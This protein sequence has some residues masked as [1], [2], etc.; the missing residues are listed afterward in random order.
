MRQM[1]I[2]N[3]FCYT[4]LHW[5]FTQDFVV[6]ICIH[7]FCCLFWVILFSHID[8]TLSSVKCYFFFY[9]IQ[10]RTAKYPINM[11]ICPFLDYTQGSHNY[12]HS[13]SFKVPHF[14][15]FYFQVF[16]FYFFNLTDIIIIII[17]MIYLLIHFISYFLSSFKF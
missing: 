6:I 9:F 1:K 4:I 7:V 10:D 2:Q 15:N 5:V 14:F 17:M 13:G 11:F 8:N 3:S 16:I 12:W